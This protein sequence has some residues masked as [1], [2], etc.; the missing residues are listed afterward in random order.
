[1]ANTKEIT[2]MCYAA[3]VY[4][5]HEPTR[6]KIVVDVTNQ[7]LS[8]LINEIPKEG[9]FDYLNNSVFEEWA[10]KNGYTKE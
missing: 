3:Q 10:K 9:L 7:D 8:D 4:S 2:F 5:T 6:M 1:M